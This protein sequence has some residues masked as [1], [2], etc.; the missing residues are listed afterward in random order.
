MCPTE[1][2]YLDMISK[3][4]GGL[5]GFSIRLMQLFCD[6]KNNDILNLIN[7]IGL[8]FQI[9]D[10]YINLKSNDVIL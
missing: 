8:Y 5:F 4:T 3:K 7:K 10:D 2:Q 1:E 9:R 6:N